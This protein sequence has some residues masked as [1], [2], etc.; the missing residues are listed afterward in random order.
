MKAKPTLLLALAL[1]AV[2][3]TTPAAAAPPL[4]ILHSFQTAEGR[5]PADG[6]IVGSDGILYGT[7]DNGGNFGFGT[8]FKMNRDGSGYLVLH[9]FSDGATDGQVSYARLFEGS[10]GALFGTTSVGGELSAGTLFRI[11]RDGSSY[12]I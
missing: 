1:A 4:S 3:T 5:Y 7:T 8:I 11:N 2:L 9:H 10:N 12:S 6:V